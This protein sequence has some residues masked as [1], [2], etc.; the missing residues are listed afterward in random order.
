MFEHI[1]NTVLE[2]D[3][4]IMPDNFKI[5]FLDKLTD[6]YAKARI[7]NSLSTDEVKLSC[8]DK[9]T[10]DYAKAEVINSLS[11]DEV[12]LSCLDKLRDDSTK[13]SIIEL[14]ST[15]EAKISCLNKLTDDYAKAR[16]INS[17]ST[18]E[19]KLSYLDKL[20][21][22][23][24]KVTVIESLSTDEV[25]LSCLD[26]LW[27]NYA[28]AEVINSLSTNEAKIFCLDK[29][30]NDSAKAEVIKSLS[31]DEVK[32]SCLDKLGNNYAKV[33]VI[34]S[35]STDK[36]K[37]SYLDKL[38]NN[39]AKVTVIKSLSTDKLKLSYLDKLGDDYSKTKVILSLSTEESKISCLDK[40]RDD[41]N[42]QFVINRL[43]TEEAKISCLDKLTDDST[44]LSII[45]LLST[46]ESKLSCL[47]KL[48]DDYS[49]V[50]VILSLSTDEAKLSCLDKLTDH[51]SIVRV[52]S[53]FKTFELNVNDTDFYNKIYEKL[54]QNNYIYAEELKKIIEKVNINILKLMNSENNENF[55]KVL[56]N[57]AAVDR[58]IGLFS[59]NN[60]IM[61]DS[62]LDSL[63]EGILSREFQI[64]NADIWSINT[65]LLNMINNHQ[66]E[67]FEVIFDDMLRFIKEMEP[68]Y[69]KK[70]INES[71]LAENFNIF[72]V[73]NILFNY[74][75][76]F[77]NLVSEEEFQKIK[78]STLNLLRLIGKK[79]IDL[80]MEVY[81]DK[82]KKEIYA[83]MGIK[84]I[85]RNFLIKYV[86]EENNFEDLKQLIIKHYPN[87]YTADLEEI[88]KYRKNDPQN[89]PKEIKKGFKELKEIFIRLYMEHYDELA[90][91]LKTQKAIKYANDINFLNNF[92]I[93]A[94]VM[95]GSCDLSG[96]Y[97]L[98]L[99]ED[100]RRYKVL[101]ELINK[102][103]L[104]AINEYLIKLLQKADIDFDME[105]LF[106]NI[107]GIIDNIQLQD[108][109]G[110]DKNI[111]QILK[112]IFNV[113]EKLRILMG[114]DNK[115]LFL[116]D[117]T[118]Y[119]STV[120]KKTRIAHIGEYFCS[121][122]ERRKINIPAIDTEYT[123]D[124]NK[125]IK[126]NVGNFTNPINLTYGERTGACMRIGGV[127]EELFDFCIKNPAGFHIRFTTDTG[128][129][130]SRVSGFRMGNTIFLN[131][132]RNS[133]VSTIS[134]N[135]IILAC[136]KISEE[137]IEKTKNSEYPIENVVIQPSV[138]ALTRFNENTN[139]EMDLIKNGV[140]V[141]GYFDT[142]PRK[143]FLV[144]SA[145]TN[146][147][148]KAV[149]FRDTPMPEYD[150]LREPVKYVSDPEEIKT[151]ISKVKIL[152]ELL[153]G[154]KLDDIGIL[155]NE[156]E[157]T[158][159][160]VGEDF[161]I[162]IDAKGNIDKYIMKNTYDKEGANR[163]AIEALDKL[164][165]TLIIG[166]NE[167]KSVMVDISNEMNEEYDD[168]SSKPRSRGQ[169]M[170]VM[171]FTISLL[172]SIL[173][174]VLVIVSN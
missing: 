127:G 151:A 103:H 85:D 55:V 115:N 47:D 31:T 36:L 6:D 42:K 48:T 95:E 27:N 99:E 66:K 59:L 61:D 18:D 140:N 53:S 11:T 83:E 118:P 60:F 44:K 141:P 80:K 128:E 2:N 52:I 8:L 39:S 166:N 15:E 4:I 9:L 23:Y 111:V 159:G 41:L 65:S 70:C 134:D 116:A 17:L 161:Y 25:K 138:Y 63:L 71:E 12:K 120:S 74:D 77:R 164:K 162:A 5:K 94:N 26:K 106:K 96:I 101:L 49:K 13:L 137:L 14:L 68:E 35:L 147:L 1:K 163:E 165:T 110:N 91:L 126:V 156:Q 105:Y 130:V 154:K 148:G 132:L 107:L 143:C 108:E 142:D 75:K 167:Q 104:F 155:E 171:L 102:Y 168:V 122:Y 56:S 82:R 3:I 7:I 24:A 139:M 150:V 129:F 133:L 174:M 136:R 172:I 38:G 152:D 57:K 34:E 10:N 87:E 146:E 51:Y 33:T 43:S 40:L 98:C 72:D 62:F 86:I 28:K 125:K 19:V 69:L 160:Y 170:F 89:A 79:Y 90:K 123:L 113:S 169:V 29:L 114:E 50:K 30:T 131:E 37:L 117:P 135:D 109:N 92:S 149:P 22:D 124:N 119:A 97:T 121:M 153:S 144:A 45:E 58:F 21:D 46:E 81:K 54:K 76:Q 158:A 84:K 100:T 93:A 112:D 20:T 145:N 73:K 16:V 78:L 157:Y 64:S 88:L 32:L 173:T 67:D